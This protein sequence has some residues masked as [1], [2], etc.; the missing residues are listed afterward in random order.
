MDIVVDG[1][2]GRDGG[3]AEPKSMRTSPTRR[4]SG[5]ASRLPA[6]G[7]A[8]RLPAHIL[9]QARRAGLTRISPETGSAEFFRPARML[10]QGFGFAP[11]YPFGDYRPDPDSVFMTRAL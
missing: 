4:R 10:Y 9:T 7:I 8:S 5:I 6:R 2:S 3:H 11:R 1:L